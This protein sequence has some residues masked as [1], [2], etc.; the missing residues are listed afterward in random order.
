M[1]VRL[2]RK[3]AARIDEIDL[4]NRSV[5]EVFELPPAEAW[6]LI[7]EEWAIVERRASERPSAAV[8]A[9]ESDRFD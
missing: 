3:L 1:R 6:L 7:A 9:P 5:G 8:K 4:T 2:T